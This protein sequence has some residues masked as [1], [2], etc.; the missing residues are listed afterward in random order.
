MKKQHEEARQ[1]IKNNISKH[2]AKR[3]IFREALDNTEFSVEREDSSVDVSF[4][5]NYQNLYHELC[6]P[7]YR[8]KH[9]NFRRW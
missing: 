6:T 3:D 7:K 4:I 1:E 8:K 2:A 9:I 5:H